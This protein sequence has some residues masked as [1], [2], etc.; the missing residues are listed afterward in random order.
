M[1]GEDHTDEATDGAVVF[2]GLES[3]LV[4]FGAQWSREKIAVYSA[5]KIIKEFINQGM[6]EA[7]ASEFFEFN[8]RGLWA[9]ERTPLILE[10]EE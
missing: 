3:A 6:T 4:G 10:D 5:S 2:P 1:D 8:V 7:D 9:G